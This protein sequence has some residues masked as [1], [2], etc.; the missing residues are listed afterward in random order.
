P[1]EPRLRLRRRRRGRRKRPR[2][3]RGRTPAPA[4][5]RT[6]PCAVLRTRGTHRTAQ[7]RP[8][9][10][11]RAV[12]DRRRALRRSHREPAVPA[13]GARSWASGVPRLTWREG[14]RGWAPRSGNGARRGPWARELA[15]LEGAAYHFRV[16]PRARFFGFLAVLGALAVPGIAPA[17]F[18]PQ[19]RTKK[20]P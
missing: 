13:A 18:N 11:A 4:R 15:R 5:R 12:P 2:P 9:L 16:R 19:G 3:R 6:P 17:Q 10:H 20:P 1:A 14:V 7:N 8:R